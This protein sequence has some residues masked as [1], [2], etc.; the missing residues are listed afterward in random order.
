MKFLMHMLKRWTS[1]KNWPS[2]DERYLAQS[3]DANEFEV[4]VQAL[5]RRR[6]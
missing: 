4:R 5:E 6:A 3:A 1:R 2:A